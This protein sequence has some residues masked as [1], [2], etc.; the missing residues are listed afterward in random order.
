MCGRYVAIM[1]AARQRYWQTDGAADFA[2][3]NLCPGQHVPVVAAD[4]LG[5]RRCGLMRWGLV[6]GWAAYESIGA[7]LINARAETLAEKPAYRK[8]FA[9]RRCLMPAEGFYEWQTAD[10]GRQAHYV[11]RRDGEP[12]TF[13]GLWERRECG[14]GDPLLTC[15]IVTTE[16]PPG[17]R[18]IHPRSPL[19]LAPDQWHDWLA[20]QTSA[21]PLRAAPLADVLTAHPVSTRVNRPAN[22]D[23]D[24]LRVVPGPTH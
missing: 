21:D 22:N 9:R 2:S 6:P 5:H 24:C 7:R 15:T 8:A 3:Y 12:M 23:P 10:T 19:V 20:S 14:D 4:R 1:N 18:A 11:Y 13:A 17:I 16:A